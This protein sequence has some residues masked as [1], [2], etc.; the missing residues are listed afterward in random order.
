MRNYNPKLPILTD[1]KLDPRFQSE[2]FTSFDI[3]KRKPIRHKKSL[4]NLH[5]DKSLQD[6]FKN[7]ITE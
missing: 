5:Q 6:L 7:L 2:E 4:S 1:R 3:L